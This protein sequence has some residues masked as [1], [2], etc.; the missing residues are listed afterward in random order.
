[1]T[2]CRLHK[3]GPRAASGEL[4]TGRDRRRDPNLTTPRFIHVDLKKKKVEKH[5]IQLI[6]LFT[7]TV[8]R[9]EAPEVLFLL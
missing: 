5:K 6:T 1:M 3:C 8:Q 9:R 4:L 2:G 7:K